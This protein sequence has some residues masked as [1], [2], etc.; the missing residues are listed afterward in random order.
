MTLKNFK[1]HRDRHF[2]F[3]P[4]TNAICGENG[5]GKTS[6]LEAIAWTLFNYRGSYRKDDLVRNGCRSAQVT[7][8]FIS[9]RDQRTY[10]IQR[11]TSKGY[12]LFDP[13]LDQRLPYSRI[14]EEVLPWLR[15]HLGVVAGTDLPRLFENTLGVPQ[16]MLTADFLL[17]GEKRKR[18][19]DSILKVEEYK[20]TSKG[21]GELQR[22]AD[23]KVQAL[24][25][26]LSHYE[27]MLQQGPEV[28]SR[29]AQVYQTIQQNQAQL[30]QLEQQLTQLQRQQEELQTQAQAVQSLE[31]RLNQMTLQLDSAQREQ[32]MR[33]EAVAQSQQAV[34]MCEQ[35]HEGYRQYQEVEMTV[36]ALQ[37]QQQERT[38]LL[39]QQQALDQQQAIAAQ[40]LATVTE[41]LRQIAQAEQTIA[42]LQPA[43]VEQEKLEAEK[44]AVE[45]QLQQFQRWAMEQE[46]L[47]A[48]LQR[49]RRDWQQQAQTI[50]RIE[51]LEPEVGSIPD[52]EQ[53]RDRLQSHLSR[54]E[55]AKQFEAEFRQ[56]VTQTMGQRDRQS[57]LI[58][59]TIDQLRQVLAN[60]P[61]PDLQRLLDTTLALL[62]AEGTLTLDI[63]Q[64]L[65]TILDD[66]AQQVSPA[67]L[68]RQQQ[69]I[70]R[71]LQQS[72]QAQGEWHSLGEQ[73]DRLSQIQAEGKQ[74]QTQI[75]HLQTQLTQQATVQAQY[76]Q[77]DQ[78]LQELNDPHKH[79][80]LLQ[81]QLVQ[82]SALLQQQEV[83]TQEL[84]THRTASQHIEEN[85]TQFSTLD[86][87]I[88]DCETLRHR[89]HPSYL[90]YLKHQQTA[91]QL[92][93]RQAKVMESQGQIDRL[94]AA[95]ESLQADYIRA[96]ETYD[97]KVL[98]QVNQEYITVRSSHDQLQGSLPEQRRLLTE[99]ETQ[100]TQLAEMAVKRDRTQAELTTTH[101]NYD[102]IRFARNAYKAAGP[103]ITER[104]VQVISKEA[105]RL[106]R[107][108]L[109]RQNV[110][111]AW[112]RDYEIVVQEGPHTRRFV[113]LSGGEQM[114]AA[115]AVRLALL[116]VLADID[117]AFF[118]EPTTN[119]DRTR[120]E[121]LAEAIANLKTFHQL[122][123][124]SHDDTFEQFTEH[125][126]LV[127]REQE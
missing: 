47:T 96:S 115:L 97:P 67:Q 59:T 25:R 66:L 100:R 74:T 72:Y 5:A 13:Q 1:A 99:L 109:N 42:T 34:Q 73:R 76:V 124:I 43:V 39:Q 55:V 8:Q 103:R 105:D 32:V 108:L 54:V 90:D 71:Q 30:E 33:Q 91:E 101:R 89:Y 60:A 118:D 104:Y 120:R 94:I 69:T 65:Q 26:D 51:A 4:G 38:A 113:N 2:K 9:S 10:N 126:I 106:F 24:Q 20:E 122:F 88:A 80:Q 27:E 78:T 58:Q 18:V 15:E 12:T 40:T 125:V 57:P 79:C 31:Q 84:T 14:E 28:E 41:K 114:C 111:L 81:Q 117:V 29:H 53:Q 77:L 46:T 87:Q 35:H 56:I 92:A 98:E 68:K 62:Q 16:G 64:R 119:M 102:F 52:L 82:K 127:Q 3:C 17:S 121:S 112:T 22:Y 7:V 61:P 123:V 93:D 49:L 6:I 37:A 95:K 85:L 110:A 75:D 11:C 45:L 116:R 19:F 48:H 107:E 70:S 23:G 36:N 83:L 50:K 44:Q 63:A 86:A 21:L